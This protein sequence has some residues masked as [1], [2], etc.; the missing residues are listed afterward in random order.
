MAPIGGGQAGFGSGGSFTGPAEALEIIGDHCYAFSGP[1]DTPGADTQVT[2]LDFTS[3]N[4]YA[5]VQIQFGLRHDTTDNISY[6]VTLNGNE[7][8]GYTITGGVGDSQQSNALN[9]IIAP[10]TEVLTAGV[11]N[12]SGGARPIWSAIVG[13]IYRDSV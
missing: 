5:V 8:C 9:L 2:L 7:V 3:G 13:R 11:N 12:S 4:Y 6:L 10:Y 1:I